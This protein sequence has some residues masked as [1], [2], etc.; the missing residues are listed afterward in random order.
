MSHTEMLAESMTLEP[1]QRLGDFLVTRVVGQGGFGVVYEAEDL[2]LQRR[3]AIKEY[4]P[5]RLAA[6]ID[7]IV[8]PVS[9][10]YAKT[11]ELG[12]RSFLAEARLLAQFSH[13]GLLEVLHFWEQNGTAYMVM[14]FYEGRTLDQVLAN[15]PNVVTEAWLRSV[16]R[17]VLDALEHMHGEDCYHRDVSADN[18]LL[19][20]D[21]KALLLDLGAAR[22]RRERS[23]DDGDAQ[24]GVRTDRA[25]RRRPGQPAGTVDRHLLRCRTVVLRGDEPDAA[26]F[27]VARD[28]RLAAAADLARAS[29][30]RPA[31]SRGDRSRTVDPARGAAAH[32]GRVP[33]DAVRGIAGRRHP[34]GSCDGRRRRRCATRTGAG[35]GDER[36]AGPADT[37]RVG[38]GRC[39]GCTRGGRRVA[40]DRRRCPAFVGGRGSA[41]GVCIVGSGGG[42]ESASIEGAARPR[43]T[44]RAAERHFALCA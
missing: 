19:C 38:C 30:L 23:R 15:G 10:R 13:P 4:L 35:E 36:P 3:V 6:R 41:A 9:S 34:G 44:G 12:R 33:L 29:R 39:R 24:A 2:T 22:D 7:G 37:D 32:R 17:P 28:A 20:N 16:I 43:E 21:G 1:G 14:P 18:I 31:L 26:R 5:A 25:V 8:V 40:C 42:F 27:G 11:F